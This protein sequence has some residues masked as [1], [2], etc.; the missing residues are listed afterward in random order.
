MKP[1][2]TLFICTFLFLSGAQAQLIINEVLYDPSNNALDG[3]ANGDGVYDQ[4]EDSFIE[5]YNPGPGNF[6]ASGYQIWDDTATGSL[7]F[8]APAG[9]FI[10]PNGVWVVFG[11]GTLV[12]DFGGAIVQTADTSANGL[13]LNNSG[14]I[15]VIKDSLGNTVL[16]FDSD[17]LSNNP[18]ESYTRFPDITGPFIQHGDTTPILF[19]PGSRTDGTPFDTLF[20]A[21]S[22]SVNGAGGVTTIDVDAGTLQ[23]EATVLPLF[24]DD[25][26]VTWSV[27]DGNIATIDP[28]GL[29]QA[30]SDGSVFAIATTNDGTNLSDSVEITITNQI[31]ALTD[32]TINKIS[33]YPNPAKDVIN[34]IAAEEFSQITVFDIH[35]KEQN[36]TIESGKIHVGGLVPGFYF[37]RINTEGEL[38]KASFIKE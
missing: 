28:N 23:M 16:T 25:K 30:V 34:V 15:I 36:V 20:V 19:S 18:N 31:V 13:N 12:G 27:S 3:D 2:F 24:A 26:S 33:L 7:K 1:I 9:T 32:F 35:G 21:E 11:G 38:F 17:A 37:I 10:P 8:V 29:V 22:V 6:N 5:F 4:E 14:E